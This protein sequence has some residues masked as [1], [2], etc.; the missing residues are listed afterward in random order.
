MA[1]LGIDE[2]PAGDEANPRAALAGPRGKLNVAF[3]YD[4]SVRRDEI[5]GS[6][7]QALFLMNGPELNRA[8]DGKRPDTLARQA[9]GRNHE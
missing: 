9:A 5:A 1:V 6:I 7:P 8:I 4:P 2:G 3:G